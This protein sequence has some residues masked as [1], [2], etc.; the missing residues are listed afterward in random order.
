LKSLLGAEIRLA[1]IRQKSKFSP[2]AAFTLLSKLVQLLIALSKNEYGRVYYTM[3][4]LHWQ[5]LLA[6]TF[7]TLWHNYATKLDLATLGDATQLEII[8]FVL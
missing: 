5:R 2:F 4:H 6:K 3:A 1:E 8:L 7:M